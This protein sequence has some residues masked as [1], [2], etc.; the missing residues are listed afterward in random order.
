[1]CSGQ[2]EWKR[3]MCRDELEKKQFCRREPMIV[4]LGNVYINLCMVPII[5]FDL[6]DEGK[7]RVILWLHQG[8]V[9][10]VKGEEV[11]EKEF[12]NLKTTMEILR[13]GVVCVSSPKD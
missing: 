1:M 12:D 10:Y 4:R 7:E 13:K 6:N 5:E 2:E 8:P 11:P 9:A 3:D